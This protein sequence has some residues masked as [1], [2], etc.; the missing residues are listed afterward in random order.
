MSELLEYAIVVLIPFAVQ[1]VIL[2]LTANRFRSLRF[3]VPVLAALAGAVYFL[4]G[5][6]SSNGLWW[7]WLHVLAF[8]LILLGLGLAL[9]G[10]GAAW[11]VYSLIQH[12]TKREASDIQWK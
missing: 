11:L 2:F 5:I 9:I 8:F 1:L 6:L 3:A 4:A 7:P 12:L 10:W